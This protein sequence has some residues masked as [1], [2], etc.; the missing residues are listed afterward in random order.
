MCVSVC[1]CVCVCV[2]QCVQSCSVCICVPCVRVRA[3][4]SAAR[5][6]YVSVR[7]R[8]NV[9]DS[10]CMSRVS[11]NHS[12]SCGFGAFHCHFYCRVITVFLGCFHCK[13]LKAACTLHHPN[14]R[15]FRQSR[16]RRA[17]T[18]YDCGSQ[19][20]KIRAIHALTSCVLVL[21]RPTSVSI[22]ACLRRG[23]HLPQT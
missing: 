16:G 22:T 8:F 17:A 9:H 19:G 4:V 12:V 5:V 6:V 21:N 15:R 23:F 10:A 7:A 18:G 3:C 2:C 1:V 20:L 13:T 14:H 11:L